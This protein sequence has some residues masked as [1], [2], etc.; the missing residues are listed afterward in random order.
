MVLN[1]YLKTMEPQSY[2]DQI[3]IKRRY[4]FTL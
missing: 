3:I 1:F 4:K 2:N